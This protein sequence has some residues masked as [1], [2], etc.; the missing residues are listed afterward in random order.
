MKRMVVIV[1][2]ALLFIAC[3][4]KEGLHFKYSYKNVAEVNIYDDGETYEK[5]IADND[6]K[7]FVDDLIDIIKSEE[8]GV[9]FIDSDPVTLSNGKSIYTHNSTYAE[10]VL[11]D[12]VDVCFYE[13]SKK[14]E[15]NNV[16]ALLISQDKVLKNDMPELT[17]IFKDSDDKVY[18]GMSGIEDKSLFENIEIDETV[19]TVN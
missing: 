18:F 7:R 19:Y 17:L 15:Y 5:D 10:I 6:T 3:G 9:G 12:N 14:Y 13:M 2:F 16:S 4:N 8:S 1:V 11:K